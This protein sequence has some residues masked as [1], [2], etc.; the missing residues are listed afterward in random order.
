MYADYMK[1]AQSGAKFGC[2]RDF[3]MG[4]NPTWIKNDSEIFGQAIKLWR[5]SAWPGSWHMVI[6][7]LCPTK[8]CVGLLW[9]IQSCLISGVWWNQWWLVTSV[10]SGDI[11]GVWW[12]TW[13]QCFF[14]MW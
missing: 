3:V 14:P 12:Q 6:V 4:E 10:V 13:N 8:E 11:S 5:A 2:M 9:Q 7:T 1:N